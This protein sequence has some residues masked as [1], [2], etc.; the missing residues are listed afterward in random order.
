[1]PVDELWHKRLDPGL[2]D[3]G[4]TVGSMATALG[5]G[6]EL[7]QYR[8]APGLRDGD[9]AQRAVAAALGVARVV[10]AEMARALRVVS[11]ERGID[12]RGL[13]LVAFG[14]EGRE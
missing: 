3:Q 1:M 2:R 5:P 10:E 11:V 4:G 12:P 7:S 8:S 13:T 6:E 14:G 9:E